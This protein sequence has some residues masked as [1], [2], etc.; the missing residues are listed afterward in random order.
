M[1]FLSSHWMASQFIQ[2]IVQNGGT[3]QENEIHALN[4]WCWENDKN[5]LLSNYIAYYPFV[6]G[7]TGSTQSII[8][9]KQNLISS[10]YTLTPSTGVTASMCTSKGFQGNGTN[11]YWSTNITGSTNLNNNNT[12]LSFYSQ[13]QST[14]AVKDMGYQNSTGSTAFYLSIFSGATE[15]AMYNQSGDYL[16]IPQS[17]STG[18][19]SGDRTGSTYVAMYRNGQIL[20]ANTSSVVGSLT[21]GV[22]YLGAVDIYDTLSVNYYSNRMYGMFSV[23]LGFTATQEA[24]RWQI[25]QNTQKILGRQINF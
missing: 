4:Y 22:I 9:F 11:S 8:N 13:T 20:S 1:S 23:G 12:H 7:G 3:L 15:V 18:L 2:R 5:G 6:G 14:G 21:T 24:L 17:S 10:N 16:S 19:F 25:E